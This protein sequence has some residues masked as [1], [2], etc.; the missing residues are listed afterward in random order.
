MA[1]ATAAARCPVEESIFVPEC[2]PEPNERPGLE[3]RLPAIV[4]PLVTPP[5]AA[6]DP[7][8]PG[9]SPAEP[10]ATVAAPP[11]PLFDLSEQPGE[12]GAEEAD[13]SLAKR[14]GRKTVW[15][16]A[17]FAL[18][19]VGAV[20]GW[21]VFAKPDAPVAAHVAQAEVAG[22]AG[23]VAEPGSPG[24]AQPPV[25][26]QAD[27]RS[28]APAPASSN[29]AA[30]AS[31]DPLPARGSVQIASALTVSVSENGRPLGTSGA[32][33]VLTAGRHS[34]EVSNE[35]TGFR[36]VREVDVRGGR[37]SRVELALPQGTVNFNASPWAEVF[38][39]GQKAG[40]TPL[41]NVQLAIGPH[42][43][44]FRHPQLGEKVRTVVVTTRGPARLS[45]D[46]Q[47]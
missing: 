23:E 26:A 8:P 42:E 30:P 6:S 22:P 35:E 45:V 20:A 39:D 28:G 16:A 10:A 18:V 25:A 12:P 5:A 3:L 37:V 47:Q 34:I 36:A 19:S 14:R 24:Q 4:S 27:V 21:A 11:R 9:P 13:D 29:A 15:A 32:P 44:K 31:A 41:G 2:E 7:A 33:I 38:V 46:M 40:E 1:V 17:A 43:V